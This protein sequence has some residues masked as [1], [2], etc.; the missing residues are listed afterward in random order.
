MNV[1]VEIW[2]STK[3]VDIKNYSVKIIMIKLGSS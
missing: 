3:L 1:I 2:F